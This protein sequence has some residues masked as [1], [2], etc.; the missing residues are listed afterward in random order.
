MRLEGPI[1]CNDSGR[2]IWGVYE[3][4]KSRADR[5][6]KV[7]TTEDAAVVTSMPIKTPSS[8]WTESIKLWMEAQAPQVILHRIAK[9][10]PG[11]TG[12]ALCT[13]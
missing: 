13:W 2:N 11:A 10:S 7:F 12:L 6:W 3:R 1:S 8:V 9:L 5:S 4:T